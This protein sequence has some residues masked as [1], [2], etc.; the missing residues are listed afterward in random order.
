[1]GRIDFILFYNREMTSS[2]K[3]PYLLVLWC[4]PGLSMLMISDSSW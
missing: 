1:M 3:I 2:S 4:P